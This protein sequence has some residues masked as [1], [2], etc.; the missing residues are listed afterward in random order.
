MR[1]RVTFVQTD[2][3]FVTLQES[4]KVPISLSFL[5]P[6]RA[7]VIFSIQSAVCHF[8]D[9]NDHGHPAIINEIE[10]FES[11]PRSMGDTLSIQLEIPF[12]LGLQEGQSLENEELFLLMHV[13]VRATVDGETVESRPARPITLSV[14][15]DPEDLP[16]FSPTFT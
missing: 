15:P 10:V 13:Q 3:H 7:E 8:L 12:T 1:P 16:L 9:A 6:G 4:T 14:L 11:L 5:P 2:P